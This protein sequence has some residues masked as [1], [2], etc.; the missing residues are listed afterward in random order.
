[1]GSSIGSEVLL[2]LPRQVQVRQTSLLA[3]SEASWPGPR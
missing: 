2:K 3:C 1:M